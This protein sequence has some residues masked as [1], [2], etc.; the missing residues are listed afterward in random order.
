MTGAPSPTHRGT[1]RVFLGAAPGVGKTYRML[2]EGCRRRARGTDVVIGLVETHGRRHTIDRIGDLEVVPRRVLRHGDVEREEMDLPALLERRPAVVLVDEL[3]HSNA[4]GAEHPKRW[5]DVEDLL[6]AGIDVVTTVNVQH[7]ESL[8]DVVESI[9]GVRQRETVPDVV[10]RRA[11]AIELVDMSPHALR[12][13]LAHGN[14]YPAE[15]VDAALGQFFR[16]GNLTALREL[17]LLWLADRVDE[18]MARYR[19]QHGIDSTWATR[20]RLVVAVT[21]GPESA[22]LLRRAAR[23]A[24][25]VGGAEWLAVYVSRGDGL[26]PVDPGALERLRTTT[27]DLG[28][29]FH[30]VTGD[31]TASAILAFARARNATQVLV[32]A[33]RRGRLSTI[34]RPGVGEIVIAESGDIDVHIITHQQ[35]R[36]RIGSVRVEDSLLGRRREWLGYAIATFG[37]VLLT[38][39][40]VLTPD[41]H[42]L[43]GESMLFMT[44]VVVTAL[45]GGQRPALLAALVTALELNFF[46]TDP[47]HSVAVASGQ[48][49]VALALFLLV[50]TGVSSVVSL[51]ARQTRRAEAAGR[52]AD[53]LSALSHRLLH[54]GHVPEAVLASAVEMFGLEGG[55]LLEDGRVVA[56]VGVVEGE[57]GVNAP[58]VGSDP[59]VVLELHGRRLPARDERLVASWAAHAAVVLQRRREAVS[60]AKAKAEAASAGTRSALLAAVSHD[61]RTPLAGVKAAVSSLRAPDVAWSP[62]DEDALLATIEEGADRLEALVDDLLDLSRLRAGA[63]VPR[64]RP[65]PVADVV[66]RVVAESGGA[67]RVR[68]AVDDEL[69]VALDAGLVDRVLANL[70]ANAL[71]HAGGDVTVDAALVGRRLL[72]RVVDTGPGVP[73]ALKGGLFEPFRRLGDVPSG[74]GVGLGLAVAQGLTETMGGTLTAEDTPGGGLTMVVD[75]PA[76]PE[77]EA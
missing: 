36:R 33:S 69:V 11:D 75:L 42:S 44:L 45:V 57:P 43:A 30:T 66:S 60:A 9:T 4:P 52:E 16:E 50:G 13:R 77:E 5:Q 64:R 55:R 38:V 39:L 35:A 71:R 14:V 67:G 1:L 37:S 65:V 34:A 48:N 72:L 18:G 54:A 28:G 15:R 23:I 31:D 58:A 49:L 10:V 17:A 56:E 74:A 29:T 70:V 47:L 6:A 7:L 3:A 12:R 2:D 19:D 8:G 22:A 46:F 27:E 68:A 32:G 63:V 21:G 73:D 62:E 24:S 26:A 41:L 76:D 53:A 25:R 20:E 51:A 61:L 59:P 40:L